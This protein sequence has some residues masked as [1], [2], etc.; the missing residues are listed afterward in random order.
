MLLKIENTR[1]FAFQRKI[2]PRTLRSKFVSDDANLVKCPRKI[3]FIDI[4]K[5]HW[6]ADMISVELNHVYKKTGIEILTTLSILQGHSD[7]WKLKTTWQ[8]KP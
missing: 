1:A 5:W 8:E 2:F 6:H 4:F 3:A 7:G